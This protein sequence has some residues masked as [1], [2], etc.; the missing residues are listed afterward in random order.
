MDKASDRAAIVGFTRTWTRSE[1]LDFEDAGVRTVMHYPFSG[2]E[3]ETAAYETLH[4]ERPV[5][6]SNILAFLPAKAGGGCST[7]ALNTASALAI[8]LGKKV[9]LVEADRRSGVLSILLDLKYQRG[10][11]DALQR[12]GEL[13]LLEWR[14]LRQH[15]YG[16]DILAAD[17]ARPGPLPAWCDFYQLLRFLQH[18]YDYFFFD[19]PELVNQA[20]AEIVKSAR[21]V[22]IVCTPEV[23][24][25]KMASQ[26]SAELRECEIPPAKIHIVLNRWEKGGL[27]I[28]D[29]E[30]VLDHPVFVRIPNDY[31]EVKR[32]ILESRVA[33]PGSPFA[34]S[35]LMFAQ[36][37]AGIP[38]QPQSRF[39]FAQLKKLWGGS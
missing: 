21:A 14:Q 17:P 38:Q 32:S 39:E 16:L 6:N 31:R 35:C 22:F 18:E 34:D 11:S 30:K 26:R 8:N 36:Q 23:P 4:R 12:M 28:T 1:G 33:S 29:V 7:V 20:T 37:L 15:V 2:P 9:L 5:S 13:T 10:L 27:K 25:L 3:L 24:S 19:L